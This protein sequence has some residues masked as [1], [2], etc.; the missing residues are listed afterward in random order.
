MVS[1]KTGTYTYEPPFIMRGLNELHI[2]F[3]AADSTR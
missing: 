1:P 2:E 3:K